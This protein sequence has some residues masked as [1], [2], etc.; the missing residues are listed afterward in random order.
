MGAASKRKGRGG[1]RELADQLNAM[2]YK[3]VEAGACTSYGKEPDVSGLWGVHIECKRVEKLNISKAMAQSVADAAKFR[4][5]R[6]AVFHRRSREQWLVTMRLQ[7]WARM[8]GAAI[9]Q[10][11]KDPARGAGKGIDAA[12]S[13]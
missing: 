13:K 9:G 10:P 1:E 8:Y 6:P 2:G 12:N 5:G 3:N 4:D 7:D 11:P